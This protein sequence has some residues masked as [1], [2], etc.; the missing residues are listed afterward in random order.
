MNP[1]ARG[2]LSIA[3]GFAILAVGAFAGGFTVLLVLL[4][5]ALA[6]TLGYLFLT[7]N[8]AAVSKR[9]NAFVRA[10]GG[11][12]VLLAIIGAN[13]AVLPEDSTFQQIKFM[14]LLHG[15]QAMGFVG[16]AGLALHAVGG[17]ASRIVFVSAFI[18]AAL[19]A[20]AAQMTLDAVMD[21]RIS[22]SDFSS[23]FKF[24]EFG[25][26]GA[27]ATG[28]ALVGFRPEHG[29][30]A[31]AAANERR[32]ASSWQ[33][34][35]AQAP[36]ELPDFTWDQPQNDGPGQAPEPAAVTFAQPHV[37]PVQRPA[38]PPR[39]RT[40]NHLARLEEGLLDGRISE[41]TYLEL[42]RKY[43]AR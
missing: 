22:G 23:T 26:F 13:F 27:A 38:P 8:S 14:V 1:H 31:H 19:I 12:T 21:G 18:A 5:G 6:M 9:H 39:P 16:L 20:V 29:P 34:V 10:A 30:V 41:Q 35:D 11:V 15:L 3:L 28:A 40:D 37:R 7:A 36:A 17:R 4:V 25:L 42:R 32:E 24:I 2:S 43:E 33:V